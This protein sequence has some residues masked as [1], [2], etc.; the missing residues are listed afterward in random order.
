MC[1]WQPCFPLPQLPD[2]AS[3]TQKAEQITTFKS[4]SIRLCGQQR[5]IF[6]AND[7]FNQENQWAD[8]SA[9]C[10]KSTGIQ[11][12]IRNVHFVNLVIILESRMFIVQHLFP[13]PISLKKLH[14]VAKQNHWMFCPG[15][16]QLLATR[17]THN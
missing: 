10:S 2:P 16:Y 3:A 7:I 6:V 5:N 8:I 1:A 4:C 15:T 14:I 12:K 13:I 17:Y 9:P 11:V